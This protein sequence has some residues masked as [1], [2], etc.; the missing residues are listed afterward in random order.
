MT[1]RHDRS[2]RRGAIINGEEPLGAAA[3]NMVPTHGHH[4]SSGERLMAP[5]CSGVKIAFKLAITSGPR[6]YEVKFE[7]NAE[8]FRI[9]L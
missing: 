1:H 6:R 4:K 3:D 9:S 2:R 5:F 8:K 7:R